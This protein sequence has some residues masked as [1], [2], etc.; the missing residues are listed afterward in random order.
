MFQQQ[1]APRAL[2]AVDAVVV[3]EHIL[4]IVEADRVVLVV[5]LPTIAVEDLHS[6]APGHDLALVAV[7]EAVV[8][9]LWGGMVVELPSLCLSAVSADHDGRTALAGGRGREDEGVIDGYVA[10][11]VEQVGSRF[12]VGAGFSYAFRGPAHVALARLGTRAVGIR[13]GRAAGQVVFGVSGRA[14]EPMHR[15]PPCGSWSAAG[16]VG[17]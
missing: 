14:K 9:G 15:T 17:G 13:S 3:L 10:Q 1:I 4:D 8:L 12:H 2:A 11:R 6:E 16:I 5:V 7:P